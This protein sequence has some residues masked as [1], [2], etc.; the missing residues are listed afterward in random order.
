[1]DHSD[2]F[3][4]NDIKGI[5]LEFLKFNE[6][7]VPDSSEMPMWKYPTLETE[8]YK[9]IQ[10]KRVTFATPKQSRTFYLLQEGLEA[11]NTRERSFFT[12]NT[13]CLIRMVS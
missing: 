12:Y 2:V 5:G 6:F 4:E 10:Q 9:R 8:V 1:M 13:R 7:Y 3:P 11:P